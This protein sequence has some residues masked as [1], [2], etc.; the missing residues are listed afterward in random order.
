MLLL[1]KS[2]VKIGCGLNVPTCGYESE[3][4]V[5]RLQ[6]TGANV[7]LVRIIPDFPLPHDEDIS[8]SIISIMP[9]G[10]EALK[11]ID[12]MYNP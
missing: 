2:A 1:W 5:K 3:R 12:E 7:K 6:R 9:R 11:L 10:L 8:D 4:M